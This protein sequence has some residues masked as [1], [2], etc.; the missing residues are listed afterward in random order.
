MCRQNG[1]APNVWGNHAWHAQHELARRGASI[2]IIRGICSL[3]VCASCR[4]SI[5][6]FQVIVSLHEAHSLANWVLMARNFV[7]A[8]I[9]KPD[10]ADMPP[11]LSDEDFSFHLTMTLCFFADHHPPR[12][13][14]SL[15]PLL[16]YWCALRLPWLTTGLKARHP[17]TLLA[18]HSA[19]FPDSELAWPV[20]KWAIDS[21]RASAR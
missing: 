6:Q 19:M 17:E 21:S 15:F 3:L 13:L 1:C 10:L 11:P 9:G 7:N 4:E 12:E 20:V 16:E 5:K 18:G 2:A 8:K 14:D